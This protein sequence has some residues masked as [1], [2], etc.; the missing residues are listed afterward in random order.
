MSAQGERTQWYHDEMN[1]FGK[2]SPQ[3][4]IILQYVNWKATKPP[5]IL[6][7]FGLLRAGWEISHSFLSKQLNRGA[8]LKKKNWNVFHQIQN[9]IN[10]KTFLKRNKDMIFNQRISMINRWKKTFHVNL[11]ENKSRENKKYCCF[12]S[13]TNTQWCVRLIGALAPVVLSNPHQTN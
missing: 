2:G 6:I 7:I 11:A 8:T 1:C 10:Q 5:K 13:Q 12:T 4:Y 3:G 9:K